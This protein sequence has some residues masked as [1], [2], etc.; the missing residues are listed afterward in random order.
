M[1]EPLLE[2]LGLSEYEAQ[3]YA[4]LLQNSPAGASLIAKKTNLSRS[5]VY[6]VLASLSSKGL[7]STTH[8]NEVKQF[9]AEDIDSLKQLV[10][11]EEA[12]IKEKTALL[13]E[14]ESAMKQFGGEELHVPEISFFEGQEGL[15]KIYLSMIRDAKK[16]SE[17]LILRDE[18]IWT[19]DW[20]FTF[21]PEWKARIKRWKKGKN[22]TTRLLVNAST[23]E[24]RKADYYASR[25]GLQFRFL[26]KAKTANNFAIYVMGD[27]VSVLSMEKG[28]PVGIKMINLHIANNFTNIFNE[29]WTKS[30]RR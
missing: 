22:L 26:S 20:H 17:I 29:I 11:S 19:P 16:D 12:K 28:A 3:I 5:T 13:P 6:T 27:M 9:V 25:K 8:K 1:V 24:K 14:I 10:Q 30:K 18:F 7:V 21:E 15:Q 2:K 23:L 4:T